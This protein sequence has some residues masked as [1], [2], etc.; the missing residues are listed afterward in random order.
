MESDLSPSEVTLIREEIQEIGRTLFPRQHKILQEAMA[1]LALQQHFI[2]QLFPRGTDEIILASRRYIDEETQGKFIL[3]VLFNLYNVNQLGTGFCCS[4]QYMFVLRDAIQ[5][6]LDRKH[7]NDQSTDKDP[8]L[9]SVSDIKKGN[10]DHVTITR[11]NELHLVHSLDTFLLLFDDMT[12]VSRKDGFVSFKFY[13]LYCV[14]TA[15]GMLKKNVGR[16]LNAAGKVNSTTERP[17]CS[18]LGMLFLSATEQKGF[19]RFIQYIIF[20][21]LYCFLLLLHIYP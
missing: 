20:N 9:V 11:F 8:P 5:K 12:S 19:N 17:I 7:G 4:D 13:L 21:L 3:H 14:Q 16:R 18:T 10:C 2:N 1:H 15:L 6:G